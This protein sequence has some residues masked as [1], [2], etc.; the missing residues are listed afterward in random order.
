[1]EFI[2]LTQEGLRAWKHKTT[3]SC[4]LS[5]LQ[6]LVTQC[7]P[8]SQGEHMKA[9]VSNRAM[10]SGRCCEEDGCHSRLSEDLSAMLLL[11]KCVQRILRLL[12][13]VDLLGATRGA[14][15]PRLRPEQS[16]KFQM[17]TMYSECLHHVRE[18]LITLPIQTKLYQKQ[19]MIS[20]CRHSL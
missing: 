10:G 9:A 4:W 5:A 20:A 3:P 6:C 1:M 13:E 18:N 17:K 11:R 2:R 15:L 12:T 8:R 16:V 14:S 19:Q 7:L